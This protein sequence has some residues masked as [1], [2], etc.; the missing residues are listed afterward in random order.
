MEK[1]T[2]LNLGDPKLPTLASRRWPSYRL[3]FLNSD[4]NF[5]TQITDGG[6]KEVAKLQK[7]THLSLSY[8]QITDAGLKEVAKLQQL[9][10]LRLSMLKSP[11]RGQG[12]G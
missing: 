6:L 12:F 2:V 7:L 1:V 11:T 3:T 4:A 10:T 8:T 5:G 9:A